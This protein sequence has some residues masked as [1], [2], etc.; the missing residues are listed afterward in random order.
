ML[1]YH[2]LERESQNSSTLKPV[3][4]LTQTLQKVGKAILSAVA[5]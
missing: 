5:I 1:T 4:T 3:K 2:S